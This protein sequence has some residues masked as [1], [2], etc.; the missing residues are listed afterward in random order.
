MINYTSPAFT[1][2]DGDMLTLSQ[3][4]LPSPLAFTDNGD[5]TYSVTGTAPSGGPWNVYVTANDGK[6]G[7]ATQVLTIECAD[8]LDETETS[9]T[10]NGGCGVLDPNGLGPG[11]P[12]THCGVG[13]NNLPPATGQICGINI[14]QFTISDDTGDVILCLDGA[15]GVDFESI[16]IGS[17][18]LLAANAS[19]ASGC[20]Q[21]ANL[22]P[23]LSSPDINGSFTLNFI[24]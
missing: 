8:V 4:N 14:T 3:T 21:W 5:G 23:P 9:V 24:C 17:V 11:E 19:F 13:G 6:G 1:D 20:Y 22:T 12:T 7:T 16:E 2:P 18:T 10:L 15:T